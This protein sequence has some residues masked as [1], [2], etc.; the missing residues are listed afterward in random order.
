MA[1]RSRSADCAES[2]RSWSAR[3]RSVPKGPGSSKRWK[4]RKRAPEPRDR[5]LAEARSELG[6]YT[7]AVRVASALLGI[8][9]LLMAIAQYV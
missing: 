3:S 6:K 8:A 9:V 1:C 7:G 2:W 4:R 5:Q